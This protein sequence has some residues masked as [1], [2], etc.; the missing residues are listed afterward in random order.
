MEVVGKLLDQLHVRRVGAVFGGE[1][2]MRKRA[3]ACDGMRDGGL[4]SFTAKKNS[5]AYNGIGRDGPDALA[6]MGRLFRTPGKLYPVFKS[7]V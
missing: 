1:L 4:I 3:L 7:H 5:Y 6:I 2:V